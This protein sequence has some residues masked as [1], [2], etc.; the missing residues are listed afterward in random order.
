MLAYPAQPSRPASPPIFPSCPMKRLLLL[1]AL[2]LFAPSALAQGGI[3]LKPYLGYNLEDGAGLL[4]G[5][6]TE[7][8][9]PFDLGGLVLSIQPGIEYHFLDDAP[10][11]DVSYIQLDGNL[12]ASFATP[13]APIAPYAGAGLAVGFSSVDIE[14]IGS[15]SSTDLGLNVLGGAEFPGAL[16]FGSPFAQA[17]LTLVD[18]GNFFCIIGGIK[19]PLGQ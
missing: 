19:V 1:L 14:G 13:G 9:A 6:G 10:G 18:G 4:V 11:V 2:P 5:I 7:L 12:V 17:R 8:A 16:G 3:A 15:D